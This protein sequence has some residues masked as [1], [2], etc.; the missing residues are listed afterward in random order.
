MTYTVSQTDPAEMTAEA[1]LAEIDGFK[2]LAVDVVERL[3]LIMSELRRRRLPHPFFKDRILSF[4]Q[5]ISD[6]TLAAEAAIILANRNMIKA[7]IP[8]PRS[9]QIEVANG[10][11]I[12][13]ATIT[14]DGHIKSDYIPIHRMDPATLSR[15]FGPGGIR[16]VQ[17]QAEIIRAEGR[18]ER[19]GAIT[20]LR[21]EQVLKIGNQKIRPEDLRGP[22]RSL[23]YKVELDRAVLGR[24]G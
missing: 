17:E 20:V 12:P 2:F 21:D 18:V 24:A 16:T 5:S 10:R 15:A 3:S 14:P 4:W 13:V 1:L 8:L 23:G 11:E 19:I 9:E 22:L 7:V 6:Q